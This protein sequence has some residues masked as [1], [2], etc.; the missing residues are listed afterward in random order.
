MWTDDLI[1]RGEDWERAIAKGI[2]DC[3]KKQHDGVVL[4]SLSAHALRA[5]NV[6]DEGFCYNEIGWVL[7][8]PSHVIYIWCPAS[9]SSTLLSSVFFFFPWLS[10]VLSLSL[11]LSLLSLSRSVSFSSSL[12]LL[13]ALFI[14]PPYMYA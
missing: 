14:A 13:T 4:L 12:S 5:K 8:A 1:P 11:S 6:G 9:Y 3:R 2:D 10:R 7:T